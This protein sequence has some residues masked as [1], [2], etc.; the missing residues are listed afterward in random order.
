MRHYDII[1]WRVQGDIRAV[2]A[3]NGA[4]SYSLHG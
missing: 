3:T 1:R 2:V 4:K